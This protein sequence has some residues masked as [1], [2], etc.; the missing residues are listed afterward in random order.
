M[1]TLRRIAAVSA[2]LVL[3]LPA[4]TGPLAAQGPV[5]QDPADRNDEGPKTLKEAFT[6]GKASL[7]LRYRY[8]HVDQDPFAEEA[9][10]STLRTALGFRTAAYEGFSL[11]LE[12]EN[13]TAL[14]DDDGYDNAG[15]DSLNNG[16]RNRPVVADPEITEIHQAYLRFERGGTAVTAGRQALSLGD[17]RFVGPVGW[18]QNHQSFDAL[19]VTTDAVIPKVEV[20]FAFIHNTN[21]VFGDNKAMESHLLQGATRLP[22]LGRLTVYGY[23][24]DYDKRPD[25]GLSTLT[26][27]A[28]VTGE[29]D[30][31]AA[32]LLWEGELARQQDAAAN[33]MEID[34]GY[35]HAMAGAAFPGVT[36]KLGYEVLEGSPEDGRF[37]TPLATLHKFNG[38]A[39]KFL[40][41]PAQG[42]E[43]LYLSLAGKVGPVAWLA[44]YHD[45]SA[46]SAGALDGYGTELDFQATYKTPWGPTVGLKGALYD[47]D[48]FATD[49]DKLWLFTATTF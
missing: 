24:L 30:L 11:F 37:T 19:T 7:G 3:A 25:E 29:R 22:A 47:A 13:V 8:E 45:F 6:Q 41:T 43:D 48:G 16:V 42:L 10:A 17:E 4:G 36:V 26:V 1:R 35:L 12:A 49:T 33:P 15:A 31:G 46:E 44:V 14:F 23:R 27:G 32:K 9:Q 34:A 2:A 18:R 40:A 20:T 21:R 38:W 28:E 39:D 5:A